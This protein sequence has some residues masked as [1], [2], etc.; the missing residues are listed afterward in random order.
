MMSYFSSCVSV[1]PMLSFRT[2]G[3]NQTWSLRRK[4]NF[5]ASRT[6]RGKVTRPTH[7]QDRKNL[8]VSHLVTV[9]GLREFDVEKIL[10]TSLG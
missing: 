1:L 4:N 2:S 9:E 8:K 6:M 5:P 7:H 10:A 3:L